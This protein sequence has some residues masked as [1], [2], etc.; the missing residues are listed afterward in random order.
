MTQAKETLM[1]HEVPSHPWE[2]IATDIFTLE[3]KDYLVTLDYYSNYW[4]VD[5]LPKSK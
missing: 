5:R 4:E 3:D 2:K 1:S